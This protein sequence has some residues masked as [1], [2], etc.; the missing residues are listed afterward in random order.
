MDGRQTLYQAF[1]RTDLGPREHSAGG[2]GMIADL[3][4]YPATKDSGVPWLGRGPAALEG[5]NRSGESARYSRGT[6]A[7]RGTR[8]ALAYRVFA[9]ATFTPATSSS[10]QAPKRMYPRNAPRITRHYVMATC[11]LRPA[12]KRSRTLAGPRSISLRTHSV[13]GGH[14]LLLRPKVAAVPEF[15]GYASDSA[16]SRDQ[17]ACMG[18]GFTVRPHLRLPTEAAGSRSH[19]SPNK[20]PSSASSTTRTGGSGGTSAPS[21]S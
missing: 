3:K 12:E 4:P 21:R 16:A 10:S 19:P 6:A 1:G 2:G 14:V 13:C 17:K 20:P 5:S 7:T 11:C 8:L 18:R 9:M 15:L